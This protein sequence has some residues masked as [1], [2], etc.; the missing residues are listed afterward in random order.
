[1]G[2]Q[3]AKGIQTQ[4]STL[5][6]TCKRI[7]LKLFAFLKDYSLLYSFDPLIEQFM[8]FFPDGTPGG[9]CSV[10][11]QCMN[12][13]SICL[14]NICSCIASYSNINGNCIKGNLF[15]KM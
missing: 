10:S 4:K 11:V 6:F 9:F 2:C 1:M 8:Y 5:F 15:S 3:Y 12:A 14:D 7:N 13:H